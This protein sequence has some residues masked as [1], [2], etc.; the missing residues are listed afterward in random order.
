MSETLRTKDEMIT[1]LKEGIARAERE[2]QYLREANKDLSQQNQQLTK[3][4]FLLMAPPVP[5]NAPKDNTWHRVTVDQDSPAPTHV[6]H[7]AEFIDTNEPAQRD[8]ANVSANT[9]SS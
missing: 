2:A 6:E 1:I 8:A 5:E 7:D 3:L 4:T 9:P